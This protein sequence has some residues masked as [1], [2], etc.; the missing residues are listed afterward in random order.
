MIRRVAIF[1][2]ILC[3]QPLN[4]AYALNVEYS[5]P[6]HVQVLLSRWP[7][8]LGSVRKVELF[9]GD[10]EQAWIIT[11]IWGGMGDVTGETY[12]DLA[13]GS[14]VHYLRAKYYLYDDFEEIWTLKETQT[15]EL[16]KMAT[17]GIL[18]PSLTGGDTVTWTGAVY[19]SENVIVEDGVLVIEPGAEVIFMDADDHGAV[20]HISQGALLTANRVSFF[21]GV[22]SFYP[23]LVTCASD[24]SSGPRKTMI[25]NSVF[26]GVDL[27]VTGSNTAFTNLDFKHAYS[28]VEIHGNKNMLSKSVMEEIYLLSASEA[29][30]EDN[31]LDSI[32]VGYNTATCIS[33]TISANRCNLITL[34]DTLNTSDGNVVESNETGRIFIGGKNN[35][36]INNKVSCKE[37]E[38]AIV[39]A[40]EGNEVRGNKLSDCQDKGIEV[41]SSD[42]IIH[43]NI[44]K[45]C[46]DTGLFLRAFTPGAVGNEITENE[47][48]GCLGDGI[49]IYGG[50]N[51]VIKGNKISNCDHPLLDG[52]AGIALKDFNP[53]VASANLVT[54]N[55]IE[56]CEIGILS[57]TSAPS[58]EP[59]SA[60]QCEDNQI[61][62]CEVGVWVKSG[63]AVVT[64]N[65]FVEND[66]HALDEWSVG[67]WNLALSPA[68]RNIV[69]GPFWGGNYYS[70]YSAPDVNG[71]Y[72]ADEPY[73]IYDL[74]QTIETYD[75]YPLL[76][77]RQIAVSPKSYDFGGLI[78]GAYS[79][80][81]VELGN[82]IDALDSL[83]VSNV[84]LTGSDAFFL[85][86]SPAAQPCGETPLTFN[87][88]DSCN[89]LVAFSPAGLGQFDAVLTIFSDDP[90]E[91]EFEA[92]F[93]GK[94]VALPGDAN[95]D[96]VLSLADAILILKVCAGLKPSELF[97]EGLANGSDFVPDGIL[98][99]NDALGILQTIALSR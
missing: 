62:Y 68:E 59:L 87:P 98:Q 7:G 45:N 44:I 91:P 17:F 79:S 63:L 83:E 97:V 95:G 18:R 51:T 4:A 34:P 2:V 71:D 15:V 42:N 94:G 47:I 9:S 52:D 25:E 11:G 56:S 33:N 92:T 50:Q 26:T 36:V 84:Q 85:D 99:V 30:V 28:Y 89:V 38:P 72:I 16:D 86:K 90:D 53:Y 60:N 70:G 76:I 88:G 46:G 32:I 29:L 65:A 39:I 12:A 3:V 27:Q 54:E 48:L 58:N 21:N 66:T 96:Y 13:V 35:R 31:T 5:S 77:P 6:S 57:Q 20:L 80:V 10:S 14:G 43:R 8:D 22:T 37:W 81:L 75:Q 64:N 78:P 74:L 1:L 82:A 49:A 24:A 40:N 93:T 73:A 61:A 55:E 23:G 67:V 41:S 69:G 19:L